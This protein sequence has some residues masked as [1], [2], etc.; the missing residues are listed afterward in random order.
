[1]LSIA[2]AQGAERVANGGRRGMVSVAEGIRFSIEIGAGPEADEGIS[3][4]LAAGTYPAEYLPLVRE[5]SRR[6]PPGGRILDLGAHIGVFS[7]AAAA[8][9]YEVVAVE[10]SP[11]N[12]ALLRSS[13][14]RNG[15]H[16]MRVIHAGVSDGAGTLRFCPFGP[17]GHVISPTTA[18]YT[19]IE[20]RAETVDGLL[21][22]LGW[23][24]VDFIKMDIEGSEVA[25]VRGMGRL[26]SRP[27]APPIF[28]E[29]NSHTLGFFGWTPHDLKAALEGFGYC[30]HRVEADHLVAARSSDDQPETVVDY[31]ALKDRPA[32]LFC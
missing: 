31:L 1:M 13:A 26:L 6:V 3:Q 20:V 27:D 2:H 4:A 5:V 28:Y 24:R 29:S 8:A 15:F 14:S 19:E 32:E 9:G 22:E 30:N 25:A 23:D 18:H 12:V 7:L 21:L 11:R 16:R 10:A 17:Y